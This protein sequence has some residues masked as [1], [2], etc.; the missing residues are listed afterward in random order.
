MPDSTG[1]RETRRIKACEAAQLEKKILAF[2][3]AHYGRLHDG[4]Q[5]CTSHT[6]DP[7]TRNGPTDECRKR[8]GKSIKRSITVKDFA[9]KFEILKNEIEDLKKMLVSSQS[10]PNER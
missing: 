3:T 2:R 8:A 1:E 9:A 10:P 4:K 6:P 5:T 7:H